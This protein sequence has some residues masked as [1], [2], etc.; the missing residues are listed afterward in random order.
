M[1]V[2][3]SG[4]A[5]PHRKASSEFV[6]RQ[7][8]GSLLAAVTAEAHDPQAGI[9]G[10]D[11]ATRRVN[12]E[13]ALFLGA[14]RAALLQLAHPWVATALAQHSNLLA[15]PIA[16]FHNTFRI[17]FTMI[18][19][20]VDQARAAARHLYALHTVIRGELT[21]DTA[22]WACCSHYEA[23]EINALRWVY[24]TLVESAVIAWECALGP[25]TAAF[26]EEYYAESRT[27][28]GL[29]GLPPAALPA[30]WK[31]FLEYNRGMHE[32]T[33]LGVSREA[34]FTGIALSPLPG[35]RPGSATSLPSPSETL[36]KLPLPAP[37][38]DSPPSTAFCRPRCA[39][40]ARGRKPRP[41]WNTA[42][43]VRSLGS[44]ISSGSACLCCRSHPKPVR[45][46]PRLCSQDCEKRERAN[47]NAS[48]TAGGFASKP[49]DRRQ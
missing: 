25:M 13:S 23:N 24:S 15:R 17:V 33:E 12:R 42:V 4:M 31:A 11:S 8:F 36:S 28:A 2:V 14:G 46:I 21:E 41:A 20:T 48:P 19:G 49:S 22:G 1:L 39:S 16:R 45:R 32:S 44:A 26:R 37:P 38:V 7:G 18:F 3:L 43:R 10:P 5:V 9:F 27:L 35:F 34:R 6:S 30:D 40:P 29:F 47:P